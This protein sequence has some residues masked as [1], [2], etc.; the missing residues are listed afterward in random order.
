[1]QASLNDW[2][3]AS[4]GTPELSEQLLQLYHQ[5]GLEGFL[6]VPYGFAALAYNAVG[7]SEHAEKYASKAKEAILM[8]DG[9]WSQNLGLWNELLENP[10]KHWSYRRRI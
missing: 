7:E 9:V 10:R 2:S 1:M 6:D 4:A 3:T 5:E 8:K